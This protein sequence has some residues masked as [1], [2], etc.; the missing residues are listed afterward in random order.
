[1][2]AGAWVEVQ[3][4]HR[5]RIELR[6][7]KIPSLQYLNAVLKPV[8]SGLPRR[9]ILQENFP[10]EGA[11]TR[12]RPATVTVTPLTALIVVVIVIL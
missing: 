2:R 8:T 4:G 3:V 11:V 7:R 5:F 10:P 9:S 12:G 6:L 1:M